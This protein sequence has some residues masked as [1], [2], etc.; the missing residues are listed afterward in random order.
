MICQHLAGSSDY[1]FRV[2]ADHEVTAQLTPGICKVI[3]E[4]PFGDMG[5]DSGMN[6]KE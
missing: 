5:M 4:L 2:G 1:D 6:R 3:V